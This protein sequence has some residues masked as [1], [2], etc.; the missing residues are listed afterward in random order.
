M[1]WLFMLHKIGEVRKPCQRWQLWTP[2]TDVSI[3]YLYI[4]IVHYNFCPIWVGNAEYSLETSSEV[5]E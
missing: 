5:S 2:T 3:I 4:L 1:S